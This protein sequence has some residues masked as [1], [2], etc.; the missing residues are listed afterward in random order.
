MEWNAVFE[1]GGVRGIA[2]VGAVRILEKSGYRLRFFAGSSAGAIVAALL[3][4]GY[5]PD[6]LQEIL[7]GLD[8]TQFLHETG[9]ARLGAVGKAA[10]LLTRF[11]LYDADL[12]E[13]WLS[14]LLAKRGVRSFGTLALPSPSQGEP[15][16]PLQVTA[17]DVTD[18]RLL[19]LPR[20]FA[21]FGLDPNLCSVAM[22]VRM[23]MSIPFFFKP[24]PLKD[25][26]GKVH[27][28][29]DGSLL[30][31]YPVWIFSRN[32]LSPS[33][34]TIG[35]DFVGDR[36]CPAV[37]H[38]KSW[39]EFF[40]YLGMVISTSMNA[41]DK[42]QA[43]IPGQAPVGTVK[44]PVTVQTEEGLRRI[45]P[46]DFE[47]SDSEKVQLFQNGEQ[48]ARRFL[49]RQHLFAAHEAPPSSFACPLAAATPG[50]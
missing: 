43:S 48:A 32:C 40:C 13:R 7:M 15:Q 3:A 9:V 50:T 1:G 33:L 37:C 30:S 49:S 17:C 22:A 21:D 20:D 23:S 42:Q 2:H 38:S 47:L 11:G 25:R 16:W 10:S 27:L 14:D 4:A 34:P 31:S 28:I 44:I 18:Q 29:V 26:R 41:V 6:E 24:F 46:I 12:F 36:A 35:F 5:T 39:P 19:L 45:S 8:F